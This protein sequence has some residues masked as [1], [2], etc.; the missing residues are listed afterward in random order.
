[1]TIGA[2]DD[3]P[4]LVKDNNLAA[5]NGLGLN[6]CID[7]GIDGMVEREVEVGNYLLA[8]FAAVGAGD[9]D[10]VERMGDDVFVFGVKDAAAMLVD[11]EAQGVVGGGLERDNIDSL[12]DIGGKENEVVS[13][14]EGEKLGV[15]ILVGVGDTLHVDAVG[16]HKTLEAQLIPEQSRND[17]AAEGRGIAGIEGIDLQMCNHHGVDSSGNHFFERI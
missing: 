4:P 8:G 9:G 13:S 6:G 5:R 1:M 11:G 2:V 14:L 15:A 7:K 12:L 17:G 10:V 16:K 3:L